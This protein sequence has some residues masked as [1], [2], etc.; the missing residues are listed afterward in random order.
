MT[1]DEDY[2]FKNKSAEV[3]RELQTIIVKVEERCARSRFPIL[4][5]F[6]SV[7]NVGTI[8]SWHYMEV[9]FL[10]SVEYRAKKVE[11]Q[12][13][14]LE[15]IGT[16]S[17]HI[18]AIRGKTEWRLPTGKMVWTHYLKGPD[19]KSYPHRTEEDL[20]GDTPQ[21]SPGGPAGVSFNIATGALGFSYSPGSRPT[22]GMLVSY[23]YA[24]HRTE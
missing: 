2:R 12:I 10:C 19:G 11:S 3:L 24:S 20:A 23:R 21:S 14:A 13:R 6:H 5:A 17:E 7:R 18:S 15:R 16:L 22:V 9:L 4:P 8:D 1:G